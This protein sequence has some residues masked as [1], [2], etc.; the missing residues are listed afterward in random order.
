MPLDP[1]ARQVLDQIAQLGFPPVEMVSPE[2]AR[3]NFKARPRAAGP[4]VAKVEDRTIPG[5]GSEISIRI[6]TPHGPGPFP[7]LVWFHGGGWVVGDLD[8]ADAT[9]R[10]LTVGA[11]CV[12]VS[13]DYR[14]APETKFPGAADDCYAATVWTVQNATSL[15]ADPGMIAVGGDSAGGNLAAVV[16]QMARDR[17]TPPL[18]F[19]LLV[20]PVTAYDF[21]TRS[22]Q[23]NAEGYLLTRDSMRWYWEQY[24]RDLTDASN[25]YAAPLVAEDLHGLPA[26]LV[27]TA[28]FDPLRDE[29]EAYARRLQEAGV[30]TQCTRYDGMMH[31]FFGMPAVLAKGQQAIDEASAALKRAFATR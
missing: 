19:Q 17:H 29:G 7:A 2:Q 1:Q 31:G 27:I 21:E 13:V 25:P 16:S 9:A 6:Y 5:P 24:L 22:Y 30:P 8:T 26:A 28:E 15:N 4:E 10:H 14:L 12:T 20:Y 3:I 11:G 18:T 23:Q